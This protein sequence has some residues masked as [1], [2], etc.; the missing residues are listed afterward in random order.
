M[1]FSQKMFLRKEFWK[2]NILLS[3]WKLKVS[4]PIYIYIPSNKYL[5]SHRFIKI[6]VMKIR[7]FINLH[8][9]L[10]LFRMGFFGAAP[11]WRRQKGPLPKICYTYPTMILGTVIPYLKKTQNT[12]ESRD[13][14]LEFCW[15]QHIFTGNQQILLYKEIQI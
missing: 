5:W 2:K 10:T 12:Y 7:T 4:L 15:H 14:P 11:G 1:P 6:T 9:I 8:V 13:I 3:F